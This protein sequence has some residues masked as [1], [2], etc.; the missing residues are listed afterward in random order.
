LPD[1][2]PASRWSFDSKW[3]LIGVPIALV[4]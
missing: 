3:V 4:V 2:G 1:A